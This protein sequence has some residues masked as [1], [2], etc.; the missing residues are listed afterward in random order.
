M[1]AALE[2]GEW[3]TARPGRTLLPGKTQYPFYRR[4]G[5][6]QG[7]SGRAENL[8]PNGIRSRIVQPVV[9]RYTDWATRSTYYH[10]YTSEIIRVSGFK[11]RQNLQNITPETLHNKW[12]GS[13]YCLD[14]FKNARILKHVGLLNT[15]ICRI[16]QLAATVLTKWTRSPL[17]HTNVT[18]SNLTSMSFLKFLVVYKHFFHRV[19]SPYADIVACIVRLVVGCI[20]YTDGS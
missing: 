18:S 11:T 15:V 2:G 20:P 17:S 7:R 1:K 5:G 6:P 19:F 4:L 10:V 16:W 3:S 12:I 14:V 8:V 13:E 9:S